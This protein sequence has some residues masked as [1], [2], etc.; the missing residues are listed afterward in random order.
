M[1]VLLEP[2][3]GP[4]PASKALAEAARITSTGASTCLVSVHESAV[5]PLGTYETAQSRSCL[6]PALV[7]AAESALAGR[8]SREFTTG[9]GLSRMRAFIHFLAPPPHLLI[10]GAGPDAQPVAAAARALGWRVSV[11]DHRPAYADPHRFP[12]VRLVLAEPGALADSVD[13]QRCHAVVVMSHH[14]PSDVAYLRVLSAVQAPGYIGLLGPSA[15]RRRVVEELGRTAKGWASRLQGPAGF[16][17]GA[18]T[19]EA[20]ALAIVAQVHA[21]LADRPVAHP[22]Q[23]AGEAQPPLPPSMALPSTS[24]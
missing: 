14:L 20:I 9:Q 12:G 24:T 8:S 4:A 7:A 3:A 23:L 13:L 18:S 16:D 1:R 10:C 19:P 5:V 22:Q 21:W 17:I 2:A 15:R 6:P 11:V